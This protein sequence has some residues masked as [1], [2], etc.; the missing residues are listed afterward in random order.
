[1]ST[2]GFRAVLAAFVLLAFHLAVSIDAASAQARRT[3]L[4]SA[5]APQLLKRDVLG[6]YDGTTEPAAKGTRLHKYLEMPLNHL[7]YRLTL[8]DISK[9]LPPLGAIANAISNA[10]GVRLNHIPM[11]PPRVLKALKA[12]KS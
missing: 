9:G 7:G 3:P 2:V 10:A 5:P 11:S 1:M 12:K 6:L 8:H 4:K